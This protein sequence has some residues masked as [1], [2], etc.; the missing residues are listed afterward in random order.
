MWDKQRIS[1]IFDNEGK[2]NEVLQRKEMKR[3]Q[4]EELAIKNKQAAKDILEMIRK[5]NFRGSSLL[6]SQTSPSNKESL[7][8]LILQGVMREKGGVIKEHNYL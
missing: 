1:T 8:P 2:E 5:N 6:P 7:G 3:K 4:A